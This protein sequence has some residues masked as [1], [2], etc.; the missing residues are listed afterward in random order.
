[1]QSGRSDRPDRSLARVKQAVV[2]RR[3]SGDKDEGADHQHHD[4][5]HGHH[6]TVQYA[7]LITD[8]ILCGCVRLDIRRLLCTDGGRIRR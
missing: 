3:V 7:S 5:N 8:Q 1:M 2:D 4:A 6:G